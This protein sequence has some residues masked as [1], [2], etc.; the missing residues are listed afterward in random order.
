MKNNHI[1][2]IKKKVA[3]GVAFLQIPLMSGLIEDRSLSAFAFNLNLS[4]YVVL[5]EV[6]EE[7]W[8]HTDM[9]VEKE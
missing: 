6:S 3:W 2:H 4:Q 8:P 7:I 1:F 9:S 5:V